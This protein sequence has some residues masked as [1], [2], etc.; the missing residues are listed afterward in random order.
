MFEHLPAEPRAW[1]LCETY[2][3]QATWAFRP[4]RREE[5]I[6]DMLSPVYKVVK[7]RT[8]LSSSPVSAHKLAALYLVFSVGA[9]VDLTL[10]PC[11]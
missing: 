10:E 1:S 11:R 3:E 8:Q 7:D 9:L 6:D 5:L 4:I 2:M